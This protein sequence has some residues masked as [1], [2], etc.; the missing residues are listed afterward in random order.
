MSKLSRGFGHPIRFTNNCINSL[1][2]SSVDV[3]DATDIPVAGDAEGGGKTDIAFRRPEE[4]YWLVEFCN[5][6]A[7]CVE[8]YNISLTPTFSLIIHFYIISSS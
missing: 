7:P 5:A 3:S 4:G 1:I 8:F 2:P 6:S